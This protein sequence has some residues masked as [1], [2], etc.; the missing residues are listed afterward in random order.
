MPVALLLAGSDSVK[1]STCVGRL[2]E[3]VLVAM[4]LIPGSSMYG[5]VICVGV[6][7]YGVNDGKCIW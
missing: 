7:Y 3:T 1:I 6:T 4:A 2:W 5:I